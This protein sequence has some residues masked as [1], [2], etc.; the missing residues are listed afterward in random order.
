MKRKLNKLFYEEISFKRIEQQ[1]AA[2]ILQNNVK[3]LKHKI[4]NKICFD[5]PTTLWKRK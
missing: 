1:L 3:Y 4:Q 5:L 2:P